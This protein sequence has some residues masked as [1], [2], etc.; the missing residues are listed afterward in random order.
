[1]PDLK[2]TSSAH[3]L[4]D[5]YRDG[6]FI[7]Y[8]D[9]VITANQ[10]LLAILELPVDEPLR[11]NALFERLLN[12]VDADHSRLLDE[13]LQGR[14]SRLIQCVLELPSGSMRKVEIEIDSRI[15]NSGRLIIGRISEVGET[16]E[17]QDST[18]VITML[19]AAFDGIEDAI[20]LLDDRDMVIQRANNAAERI[21]CATPDQMVGRSIL[22]LIDEP[23]RRADLTASLQ[24][25]LRALG[26]IHFDLSMRRLSGELFPALHGITTIKDRQGHKIALMWIVS[27]VSH[28][29]TL[30]RAFAE[31]ET[32]YRLLFD[33][34]ADPTF[35]IDA[36]TQQIIDVNEAASR[37]LGYTRNELIGMTIEKI[38]P[39]ERWEGMR[40]DFSMLTSGG[41]NVIEGINLTKEGRHIPVQVSTVATELSGRRVFIAASRDITHQKLLEQQRLHSQKLEVVRQ[42]A[43]GLAHELSQPLQALVTIADI[44]ENTDSDFEAIKTL[45]TKVGPSVERMV[46]LID[47]M[48]RIV[49]LE[50]KPYTGAV[51]IVDIQ[52]ST[53]IE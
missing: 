16:F 29:V 14:L 7:I 34:S 53:D 23:V 47:Q 46:T 50:T 33:R 6:I 39:R 40:R 38:T 5:R 28:R 24:T 45:M 21:F 35:I 10:P 4:L 52:E 19:N 49:K 31:L 37:Q 22:S 41:S 13:M 26:T 30:N 11:T 25:K 18:N 2:S 1:M 12:T 9:T 27:D 8:S 32:R 43:G 51:D 15:A 36:Q 48:K 17:I 44:I 20:F 42:M 3:R